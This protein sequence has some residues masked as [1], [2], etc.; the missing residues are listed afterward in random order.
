MRSGRHFRYFT[1]ICAVLVCSAVFISPLKLFANAATPNAVKPSYTN[2][3]LLTQMLIADVSEQSLDSVPAL[4]IT[5]SQDLDTT[6]RFDQFFT[7]TQDG[8]A[9]Q[10]G[11]RMTNHPRRLYFSNIQPNKNYRI[12]VRPGIKSKDGLI[13]KKPGDFAVKTRDIKPAFDFATQGS[14]L[15]AQLTN[16]LPVRVVNVPEVD[17]EFLRVK[18]EQVKDVLRSMR[19]D[20]SIRSWELNDIH[21]I[22][23]SVY[24]Q[25]YLTGAKKNA[26]ET[27]ILPVEAMQE[28]SEPGLYFAIMRQPGKFNESAYRITHFIVTNIGLH[29]RM[30]KKR[31]EVFAHALDSG[32]AI[33]NVSLNLHGNKE[34]LSAVSDASGRAGF[35]HRPTGSLV[36][37]AE[38]NGQ[39]AFLDLREAALDL[40]EYRVTGLTDKALM[41]FVYAPRDLYRPGETVDLSVML[42]NRDGLPESIGHL[43]LRLIR[44]DTK[45]FSEENIRAKE[46]EL[47]YFHQQ[48]KLPAD[49][50]T[51]VWRAEIRITSKD[52]A[53]A[54]SF[55][56]HVEEFMPE[57]MK[58]GLT[59]AKPVLLKNEKMVVSVQ[60]DYLYGA[61]AAGNELKATRTMAL[62]HHPSVA[63]KDFYFGNPADAKLLQR[64]ELKPLKLDDKGAA[65]L[66][67][68]PVSAS[69]VSPLSLGVS[70]SLSEPGGRV[71]RN[72]A[73]QAYWPAPM[74]AGIKPLFSD[75]VTE[76]DG[77]AQFELI[78]I[79]ANDELLPGEELAATLIK[80]DY[81]YFWEYT[82]EEGWS[83]KEIRNEYPVTQEKVSFAAG[84]KGKVAFPV[85]YG[86]YRLEI[87]DVQTGL[88]T[89]YPFS[90]GWT[91]GRNAANRPD[92]IE[93]KLDKPAYK[94]GDVAKLS[95]VPATAAQAVITVEADQLLW[96]KTVSLPATETTIDI[97]VS[98]D[99]T[100]HDL[101]IAVT[102]FRPANS[103]EKVM[104]NRGLG[105]IHLPLDRGDRKLQLTVDAPEK[106]IPEKAVKVTVQADQ[107]KGDKAL[108]TLA[109]VDVGVLNITKFKTPDPWQFFFDQHEYGVSLYDDYGKIIESVDGKSMRQRFG[110]GNANSAS[111]SQS[112]PEVQIVSLFRDALTFDDQGKAEVELFIPGFDGQLRLMAVAMTPEQMGST[113]K[114]ML[115]ASPVVASLSG[116]RFLA[117]GDSSF[118]SIEL[119]NTTDVE[120][121]VE[122]S[123]SANELL[124]FSAL[125]REFILKPKQSEQLKLPFAAKQHIGVGIVKLKL[126]GADFVANRKI[127][128]ALRPPYPMQRKVHHFELAAGAESVLPGRLI[129]SLLPATLDA[130]LTVS[131]APVLP[132]ASALQGLFSYP[133]GCLEQTASAAYPYL[134]LEPSDNE[135]LGL[136]PL[137]MEVRHEKVQQAILRLA[138]MQ[139][140][141]GAFT[142]WGGYGSPERWLT[143]YVAD[144][145]L[146]ARKQGFTVPDHLLS[147]VFRNLEAHL[148][149]G[150]RRPASRYGFSD[151]PAHL[152]FAARAYA[153]YVLA[154]ENR[155]TLGTLRNMMTNDAGKA[156]AGLPLVHLGLALV[157]QGDKTRGQ[158]AISKGLGMVRSDDV[159]LG[160][161]GSPVRDQAMILYLLLANKQE[162]PNLGE[163]VKVLTQNIYR[164]TYLS[165]QEQVFVYLLGQQLEQQAGQEWQA[166][167]QI[168]NQQV[169]LSQS[170]AYVQS[171]VAADFGSALKISSKYDAPLYISLALKGYPDKAP[172]AKDDPISVQRQWHT[173]D[174]KVIAADQIKTGDLLLTRLDIK[175]EVAI[176]DA[177]VVD[178]L[179]SG[180]EIENTNLFDNKTLASVI[181]EGFTRT[182]P[183]ILAS[184]N[185]NTE[186]FRDDRYVAALRL[187]AGARY[188]L[189]YLV[190]VSAAGNAVVPPPL[191]EDMYRPD[192]YGVGQSMGNLTIK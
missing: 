58:L 113:E 110:G 112:R 170:G 56:F 73:K 160:D 51:G 126:T 9:L 138:G 91:S 96:S 46:E 117:S 16:G 165:T 152:D 185:K 12:Q 180:F 52:K 131:N 106:V 84:E 32:R 122:L 137:S 140:S 149:E 7:V 94:A 115:V 41:P 20:G 136:A 107:L 90:A 42:R 156:V 147:R 44:P 164:R 35:G 85:G 11:W 95:I 174:G 17:V 143:P 169:P 125:G 155:A 54:K 103:N 104:P 77:Q 59:V 36:L 67:V 108:V 18:P 5:F 97:P 19:L 72:H 190:R 60:G 130:R 162:V 76:K 87:E 70:A 78:R 34:T 163:R 25:R 88:K 148:Q 133:Y 28:L 183:D 191:V 2:E 75:G 146:D 29:V 188:Q 158:E 83:R 189:F 27:M 118:L 74:L 8:Q 114:D 26:R 121:K 175:S 6:A 47:G 150:Y 45:L 48:V 39:F 38:L 192:L 171:L 33:E 124:D 161:Y 82:E 63:H 154:R 57:R 80:E 179:P 153:A 187:N 134:F 21:A 123:V 177:L 24:S 66:E 102:A 89:V 62:N 173:L 178:L 144:F 31:L 109:A 142:L 93:L 119:N 22:T 128:L 23:R 49:A 92:Q 139:L 55:N 186:E 145:L 129:D 120:Q 64:E 157:L 168:N 141:N 53:P 135:R 69:I 65:M 15:P 176:N 181:P 151:H 79:N 101:Y 68:A 111:G 159:Y 127:E 172:A 167:L 98:E 105:I 40:S 184:V 13:L 182:V 166:E 132:V 43:N 14:I 61:P 1:R 3:E 100:R 99:W 71:V 116:P 50:P 10:G 30:Y 4:S 86:R 81:E 37:T